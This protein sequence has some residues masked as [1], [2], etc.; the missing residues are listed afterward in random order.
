MGSPISPVLAIL[1]MNA[2][3]QVALNQVNVICYRRYVDDT[4][5]L[6]R[7]EDDITRVTQAFNNAHQKIDFQAEKPDNNN[8][9]SLLD[10]SVTVRSGRVHTEFY[11]KSAKKQI[12]VHANSSLPTTSKVAFIRKEQQRII[13]RC[14]DPL[15]AAALDE[16]RGVLLRNGYDHDTINIILRASHRQ[17]RRKRQEGSKFIL[18]VPYIS[19]QLDR[20]I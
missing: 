13:S 4:F 10:V 12:C 3:E 2:V 7:N 17:R 16:F 19:D 14:S 5:M 11:K 18:S 15:A 20:D 8:K 9:L 1:F 6:L